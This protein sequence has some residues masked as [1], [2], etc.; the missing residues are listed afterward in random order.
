MYA[1]QGLPKKPHDIKTSA[2]FLSAV[3]GTRTRAKCGLTKSKPQPHLGKQSAE[4]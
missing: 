4:P 2:H 1:K 3:A